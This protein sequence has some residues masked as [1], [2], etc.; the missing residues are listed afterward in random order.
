MFIPHGIDTDQFRPS[1]DTNTQDQRLRLL[2]VGEHMRDWATMHAMADFC[3]ARRLPVEFDA[4]IPGYARAHFTG[5]ANVR[6]HTGV[7][8]GT[9]I[10]LY[11]RAD[12]LLLPVTGA[13]A[14][15]SLL[16]ALACGTPAITTN[17]GGMTDY[18][19]DASGWLFPPGE[20][21]LVGELIEGDVP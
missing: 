13:T 6:L 12:A 21:A 18:V 10:A 16:E 9:L 1:E 7:P 17:V 20:T 3:A 5:C 19:D 15:N 14:N 8:E 2:I 11:Q 4:V